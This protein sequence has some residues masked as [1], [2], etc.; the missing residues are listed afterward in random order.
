MANWQSAPVVGGG[1]TSWQSAPAVDQPKKDMR[2]GQGQGSSVTLS[3]AGKAVDDF[4]RGM[5]DMFTFGAADEV[6]AGLSSATGVG[7][8]PGGMGDYE[9]NLAAERARDEAGGAPRLAGQVTGALTGGI[10]MGRAGLTLLNAA[11]PTVASMAGRGAAEGAIYGGLYGAG[12]GEG[13]SQARAE[14]A[15]WGAFLGSLTGGAVGA[16][17]GKIAQ[18]AAEKAVPTTQQIQKAGGAAY[19]KAFSSGVQVSQTKFGQIADD[20]YGTAKGFGSSPK[21]MPKVYGALEE[22]DKLRNGTPGLQDIDLLRRSLKIAAGST[23]KSERALANKLIEQLDDTLE[24]LTPADVIAGN[25]AEGTAALREARS[26][27]TR[28]SKAETIEKLIKRAEDRAGQYSN[29]G[30]ENAL[31]T[32]FR[33]LAMNEKKMRLFSPEEQQAIKM[34]NQ[35]TPITNVLRFIGKFAPRGLLSGAFQGGVMAVNPALGAGSLAL[36]EAGRAGAT[37]LTK[38]A[39]NRAALT[40]R[41]GPAGIPSAAPLSPQGVN[42]LKALLMAPIPAEQNALNALRTPNRGQ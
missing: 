16:V 41:A 33:Q 7:A 20:L 12:S 36:S 42:A 31:R 24:R 9:S 2:A 21:L 38:G 35:G 18:V 14:G 8:Q 22:F 17:G 26:L 3:E 29:S 39:A 25:V 1:N 32:E 13:G 37:A 10:G 15:A 40:M 23:E 28:S 5:A 11:K 6:A 34:I 19:D 30:M 4:V 27:W